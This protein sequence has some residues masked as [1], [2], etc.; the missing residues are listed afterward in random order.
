MNWEL[1]AGNIRKSWA[2][3][4]SL[5]ITGPD[6]HF[7]LRDYMLVLV[8]VVAVD[9]IGLFF[10]GALFAQ[11]KPPVC[12]PATCFADPHVTV[13]NALLYVWLTGVLAVLTIAATAAWKTGRVAVAVLQ[14]VIFFAVVIIAVTTVIRAQGQQQ[15]LR[16][17]HAG[18][19]GPC[20]GVERAS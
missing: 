5:E 19:A 7:E 11:Q 3:A 16:M 10:G 2:G 12:G 15:E 18:A 6:D 1:G 9:A 17:C 20:V 8:Y 4:G 14:A 13:H